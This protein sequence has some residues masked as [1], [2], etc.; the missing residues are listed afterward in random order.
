MRVSVALPFLS[1]AMGPSRQITGIGACAFSDRSVF[2]VV[3]K[4]ARQR[5]GPEV[6]GSLAGLKAA[7]ENTWRFG[8]HR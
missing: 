5:T 1:G 2:K 4:V 3:W 7:S 8:D 6:T